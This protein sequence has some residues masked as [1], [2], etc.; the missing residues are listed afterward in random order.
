[1]ALANPRGEYLRCGGYLRIASG[2]K[3]STP[4]VLAN[5]LNESNGAAL[6]FNV[7]TD[8]R[9]GK[10]RADAANTINRLND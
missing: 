1:M 10:S 2:T 7:A 5:T 9:T 3:E 6:S 4:V 8:V